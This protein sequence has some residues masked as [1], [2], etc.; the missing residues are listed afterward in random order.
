MK[1][2]LLLILSIFLFT[3]TVCADSQEKDQYR[4]KEI[5]KSS[6]GEPVIPRGAHMIY[7]QNFL[8]K[9]GREQIENRLVRRIE[10][11][12]S[13][14]GRLAVVDSHSKTDLIL[15]GMVLSFA[16]QNLEF[17]K[18]GQPVKKRMRIAASINLVD[19]INMR[20]VFR[21]SAIESFTTYSDI[22]PPVEKEFQ[23]VN[24]VIDELAERIVSKTLTGWYTDKMTDVEKGKR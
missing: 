24:R 10:K 3:G 20:T 18:I 9:S 2:T 4:V 1:K 5:L 6:T 21:K 23:V 8:N 13:M 17:N 7:I 11:L 14:D 19:K 15:S 22:L 12:I 16:I